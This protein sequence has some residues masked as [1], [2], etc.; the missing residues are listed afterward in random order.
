MAMNKQR[1]T[2]NINNVVTYDTS[3]NVTVPASVTQG[4]VTSS[5]LK[6][7]ANGKIIGAVS[8][9]DYLSAVT[10]TT[11]GNSGA[12][13]FISGVLNVPNYTLAG[14][15]GISSSRTLTI[16]TV[17]FDLSADRTW[18][19]DLDSVTDVSAV[20]TNKITVGGV[21]LTGMTA[22]TAALYYSATGSKVALANNNVGG[23]LYF[24]VNGGSATMIMNADLSIRLLGY[25]SNGFLKTSGSNG[26]LTVDTTSYVPST[27]NLT[28]NGTTYDLSA[29]RTWTISA[30]G[31]SIGG[32]VTSATQGSVFFAGPSG[33]LAQDN[34]NFFW[35]DSLNRLRV[36]GAILLNTTNLLSNYSMSI[37]GGAAFGPI[38]TGAAFTG[39]LAYPSSAVQSRLGIFDG[40]IFMSNLTDVSLYIECGGYGFTGNQPVRIY[41]GIFGAG[42]QF[43]ICI[44][45]NGYETIF[46]QD[47]ITT[48]TSS[49]VTMVSTTKGFLPPR[50]TGTQRASI[51]SPA[52]G[53]IVYQTDG[54]LGLYVKNAAG[55][56]L[57]GSGGGGGGTG[58]VTSVSV[59]TANG[60]SGIVVN[61]T[62]TPAIT[63]RTTVTGLL[64]G[65]GT[66]I[67]AAVA[68]T[69]YQEPITLTTTGTT[70]ASTK[71]GNTINVPTY[72]GQLTLTTTGTSGAS[73]LVGNTLNIPNYSI[74]SSFSGTYTPT[75]SSTTNCSNFTVRMLQY[76]VEDEV[77]HVAGVITF[78]PSNNTNPYSFQMSLPVNFIAYNSYNCGGTCV[79]LMDTTA[80]Q[81]TCGAI[82]SGFS[83]ST[84][85]FFF[86]TTNY[87]SSTAITDWSFTF[88]YWNGQL[89]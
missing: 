60:F 21:Y 25:T 19:I 65:N 77:V 45:G 51:A 29:D 54:A 73:S 87:S 52:T 1:R 17:S 57:L 48:N 59:T 62:T 55:W 43:P 86:S 33:V 26:T 6:A 79:R 61:D 41:T 74:G 30:S 27:R 39:V 13:T 84:V 10:L 46:G 89:H 85:R 67:S 18:S 68:G 15:G 64:K 69:D 9:T 36:N 75:I 72:Q 35:D 14:L 58:T 22:G 4:F 42:G 38:A 11:I 70:G 76:T 7:D 47:T 2:S 12:S 71:V 66:A 53:L 37:N 23:N 24:E 49:L 31:M 82:T 20:T 8:G 78:S 83:F 40:G 28:I 88:T 81:P 16:N 63:I 44:Q 80:A 34:A 3:N 56:Q 5:M 32:T 50:M